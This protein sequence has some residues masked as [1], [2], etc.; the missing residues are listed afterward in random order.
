MFKKAGMMRVGGLA[1]LLTAGALLQPVSALAADRDHG[2]ADFASHNNNARFVRDYRAPLPD[3]SWNRD[4]FERR[5]QRVV[6]RDRVVVRTPNFY[7]G[8]PAQCR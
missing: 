8:S 1:L 7:Y 5:D 6:V 2:R 3:Q 4:R